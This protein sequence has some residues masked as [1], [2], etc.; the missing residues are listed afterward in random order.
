VRGGGILTTGSLTENLS[1]FIRN[2]ILARLLAPEAFG[3]VAT[4]LAAVAVMEAF[5]EVG[6][7]QSVIQNKDGDKREFLNIIWWLS[8]LRGLTLYVIG[9]FTAPV[10]CDFYNNP[11]LLPVLRTVFLVILFKGLISPRVHVLEKNL[12]F[13]RWVI[14]MQ[15]S[16][17]LGVLVSIVSAFFLYN[18]W[19]LILGYIFEAMLLC[20]LSFVLCPF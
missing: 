17:V 19:A 4:A 16:G 14:I 8:S 15:G 3:L 12:Q 7:G 6:F 2:I 13:S 5:S 9:Y 20:V 18:V 1:R 10:I 11:D